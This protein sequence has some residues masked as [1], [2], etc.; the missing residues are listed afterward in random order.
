MV[1][2]I[3]LS[4][5]LM[6]DIISQ[7]MSRVTDSIALTRKSKRITEYMNRYDAFAKKHGMTL[8]VKDRGI[9]AGILNTFKRECEKVCDSIDAPATRGQQ[10]NMMGDFGPYVPEV[11][12]IVAAW[13]PDFPL[14]DL[15]S[16][17]DMSQD[18][19]F[20]FFSK[21][22]TGTNKAPTIVG[23]AVETATGMRQINGYYPTGEI[24]GETIPSDQL[25][26][27]TSNNITAVTA[28]FALNVSGDYID[29]FKLD[30]YDG[31]ELKASMI[32]AGVIG[33]K[34]NLVP[35]SAPTQAPASYMLISSGGIFIAAADAGGALTAPCINANYVWNLDYAIQ[36][37]IPK[38]KEQVEKVEMR[39]IPRAI[40]MEWT[41]FAE[42]LKKSQFGTDIR[43][44]N[45]KR[46]LNLM[47]Q[48]QVRY[49]LDT[50]WTFATGA[51][52][53]IN[54]PQSTSISLDVQAANVMQQLKQYATQIELAS[55]RIEGNRLVVGKNMKSFLESLP[56]TWF[57]PEKY[58]AQWSA[59][60]AIGQFG[61]FKVYYDP[62]RA[63][64]AVMMTYRGPEWYDAVMYMGIFLPL[65]PTDQVA[66]G[67]TVRQSMVSME[68][69]KLHKANCISKLT[70]RYV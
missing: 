51:T 37:N 45:T 56:N 41:I 66:I 16:V 20:L 21:L 3:F 5:Y 57:Q 29:K 54:I 19:A 22:V 61:S 44:E 38:V 46:V 7:E 58:Q 27:D 23:Q 55:G 68:A 2:N 10:V 24:L 70:V 59:A 67:V 50:M 4:F 9:Q 69:Y 18:L 64:D 49:I 31:Q 26:V 1:I 53:T 43:T 17:Q 32:P 25:E 39:A 14:K 11:F 15:I 36:E 62:W 60:R 28:Y 63:D 65:V 34:I 8:S 33:D 48:Y 40:G 47:Y 35:A 12:P 52:G 30:I 42:A 13:Y 6:A